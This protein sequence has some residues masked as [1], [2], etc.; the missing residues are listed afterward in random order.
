MKKN[1][2]CTEH[3]KDISTSKVFCGTIFLNEYLIF[4][5]I[6]KGFCILLVYTIQ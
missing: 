6:M 1:E 3:M 2:G 4:N 5:T